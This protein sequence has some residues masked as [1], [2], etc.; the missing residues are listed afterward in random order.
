MSCLLILQKK[1]KISAT[2]GGKGFTVLDDVTFHRFDK[3]ILTG[4][5]F[6]REYLINPVDF[7]KIPVRL[8]LGRAGPKV[9]DFPK[10]IPP[11]HE[12]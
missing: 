4:T 8:S 1:I 10:T 12:F 2:V 11:L 5:G 9:P 6:E 7:E 3:L